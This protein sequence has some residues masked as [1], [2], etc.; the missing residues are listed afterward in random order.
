[1]KT[2]DRRHS[3]R[4]YPRPTI[5]KKA[6]IEEDLFLEDYYDDWMDFR[7]GMRNCQDKKKIRSEH[8]W[9]NEGVERFNKKNKILLNRR[10]SKK[11]RRTQ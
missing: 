5:P 7:D 8:M 3:G 6:L 10:K 4:V 2:K 9:N 11:M 1:M